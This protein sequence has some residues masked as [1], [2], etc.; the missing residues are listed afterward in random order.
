MWVM[1]FGLEGWDTSH[2]GSAIEGGVKGTSALYAYIRAFL[3]MIQM[4]FSRWRL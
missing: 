3:I 4:H 2:S 1:Y